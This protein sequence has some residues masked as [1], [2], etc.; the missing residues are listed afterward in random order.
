M[1]TDLKQAQFQRKLE[2]AKKVPKTSS[3]TRKFQDSWKN[4]FSWVIYDPD[5][6]TMLC[7]LCRKAGSKIAGKTEF[8]PGSKN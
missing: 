4:E 8:V 7:D 1:Q 3:V 5:V 2:L 6:N